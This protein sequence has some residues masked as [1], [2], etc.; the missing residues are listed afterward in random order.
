MAEHIGKYLTVQADAKI[1]LVEQVDRRLFDL[2]FAEL[3]IMLARSLDYAPAADELTYVAETMAKDLQSDGIASDQ[4]D[5]QRLQVAF[6]RH[7]KTQTRW[8]TAYHIKSALPNRQ[9]FLS[10]ALPPSDEEKA[11]QRERDIKAHDRVW[12]KLSLHEDIE[13]ARAA[14]H[15]RE[16]DEAKRRERRMAR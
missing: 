9:Q 13:K 10:V 8:P 6:T 3:H 14:R 15:R 1:E 16:Q 2:V 4:I 5:L 12:S 11:K 7:G